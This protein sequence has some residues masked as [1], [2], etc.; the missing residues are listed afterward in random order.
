MIL[1]GIKFGGLTGFWTIPDSPLNA[2]NLVQS[3]PVEMAV[4]TPVS[5][6]A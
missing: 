2:R 6:T 3:D 1:L 5:A 4:N